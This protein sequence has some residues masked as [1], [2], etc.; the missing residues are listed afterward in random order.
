MKQS[1][2]ALIP[3]FQ[4]HVRD[5]QCVMNH[6][7]KRVLPTNLDII[8]LPQVSSY[9][10]SETSSNGL[11]SPSGTEFCVV[12]EA[13]MS[14]S[15]DKKRAEWACGTSGLI[16]S[17]C[18]SG[19]PSHGTISHAY[20]LLVLFF[21]RPGQSSRNRWT[22]K[23]S[24]SVNPDNR[25]KMHNRLDYMLRRCSIMMVPCLPFS[26]WYSFAVIFGCQQPS[27]LR[28]TPLHQFLHIQQ[29]WYC[30][31]VYRAE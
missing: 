25:G 17:M 2:A 10:L 23:E 22:M 3:S 8:R 14:L 12:K 4:W 20:A 7:L 28:L 13:W 30:H 5:S 26:F 11:N 24:K 21:G 9:C 18:K 29:E 19:K 6:S 16:F 15:R 1:C 31:L 27:I